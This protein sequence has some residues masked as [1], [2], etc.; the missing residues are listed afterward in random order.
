MFYLYIFRN[1]KAQFIKTK[2]TITFKSILYIV[3]K[4]YNLFITSSLSGFYSGKQ[5]FHQ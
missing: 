3:G 1:F 4:L 2:L 5:K